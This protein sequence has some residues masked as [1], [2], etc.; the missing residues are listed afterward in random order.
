MNPT[1]RTACMAHSGQGYEGSRGWWVG[2]AATQTVCRLYSAR[3]VKNA[4]LRAAHIRAPKVQFNLRRASV[5]VGGAAQ[6]TMRWRVGDVLIAFCR[7][8]ETPRLLRTS[9]GF[10]NFPVGN[11]G[12]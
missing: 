1:L 4:C 9:S 6:F 12:G 7:P 8:A 5:S 3:A 10:D 11:N 2:S